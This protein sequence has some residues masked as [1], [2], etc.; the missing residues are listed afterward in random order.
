MELLDL[1]VE[2]L[3]L[4]VERFYEPW[5]IH[6]R[7]LQVL[8]EGSWR[9]ESGGMPPLDLLLTCRTLFTIAREAEK[10]SFGGTMYVDENTATM[11]LTCS[12][13]MDL[14][15]G[16]PRHEWLQERLRT[17]SFVNPASNPALWRVRLFWPSYP[18]LKRIELDCR[19]Q[20][21]FAVH[22]VTSTSEFLSG[23][24]GVLMKYMDFRKSFFLSCE[25]FFHIATS[26]G[27]SVNVIRAMGVRE[28]KARCQAVVRMICPKSTWLL[29]LLDRW[30]VSIM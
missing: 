24:D 17:I 8:D 30:S 11:G 12:T 2:I 16:T 9:L 15:E 6:L 10:M 23:T 21:H 7:K 18:N 28:G 19:Y 26:K 27:V 20:F 22:N 3:Q 13:F 4:V 1:P 25:K 29:I 14:L 5:N